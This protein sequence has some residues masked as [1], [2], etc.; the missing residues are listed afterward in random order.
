MS[1]ISD[2]AQVNEVYM[3]ACIFFQYF[4]NINNFQTQNLLQEFIP[5]S[6]FPSKF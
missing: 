6:R 1:M 4:V 2:I 5:Y 3:R